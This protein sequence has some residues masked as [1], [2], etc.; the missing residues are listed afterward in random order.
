MAERLTVKQPKQVNDL[1]AFLIA[2]ALVSVGVWFYFLHQKNQNVHF[3]DGWLNLAV[4]SAF[5]LV[6]LVVSVLILAK[7]L[8]FAPT[9]AALLF[10]SS[11]QKTFRSTWWMLMPIWP[12]G[13]FA[14]FV[15]LRDLV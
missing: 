1:T 14:V 3:E 6:P 13:L 7:P 12:P 9:D 2:V 11:Y 5:I 10:Y 8:T 15:L 4:H